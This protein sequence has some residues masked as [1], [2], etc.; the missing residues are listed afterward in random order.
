MSIQE[1]LA[2]YSH[3]APV[4]RGDPYQMISGAI[5][6]K[7]QSFIINDVR[8][9]SF[10]SGYNQGSLSSYDD[11]F[12][13]G[14]RLGFAEGVAEGVFKGFVA[15][16]LIHFST[17]G[18]PGEYNNAGQLGDLVNTIYPNASDKG[19][20]DVFKKSKTLSDGFLVFD[21]KTILDRKVLK[22]KI[23]RDDP[24]PT[25][26]G[27]VGKL[28]ENGELYFDNVEAKWSNLK[29]RAN[30]PKITKNYKPPT[31]EAV[32]TAFEK[33]KGAIIL[34]EKNQ[35]AKKPKSSRVEEML[36]P[37]KTQRGRL[38]GSP[39]HKGVSQSISRKLRK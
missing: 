24:D 35:K 17:V 22:K 8:K 33:E 27:V 38:I 30:V 31:K 26:P 34:L 16:D 2:P 37:K 6:E 18:Q 28:D 5:K 3:I 14:G 29:S 21:D 11:G 9:N 39:K 19:R 32:N 4:F 25:V 20:A 36:T 7:E 10:T 13:Y 15:Q 23:T 12:N 1:I